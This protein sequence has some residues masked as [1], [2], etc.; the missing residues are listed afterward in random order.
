MSRPPIHRPSPSPRGNSRYFG[1]DFNA[2]VALAEAVARDGH[3]IE[4]PAK[5]RGLA[6]TL[7]ELPALV[8]HILGEHQ[9]LYAR[10]ACLGSARLAENLTRH[11]RKLAYSPGPG[12]AATGLA[13]FTV[14]PGLSGSLPQGFALQTSPL[15]EARAQTFETLAEAQL[16][17]QWNA[18]RPAGAEIPDPV[19]AS[20]GHLVLRLKKRHGLGKDEIVV[21]DGARGLG[22]F[23]VADAMEGSRPPQIGLRHIGGHAFAEAGT[24]ADWQASYRILAR[25]RHD[26][27]LFGWNAPG[28]LWPAG[29]LAAAQPYASPPTT[30]PAGTTAFGYVSPAAL[31]DALLLAEALNDPPAP[32]DA[33]V[34]LFPDRAEVYWLE[35]LAET[36]VT[37]LRGEV[38]EQP[39][40]A[41]STNAAGA[42]V[43]SVTTEK[44]VTETAL[45]GRATTLGLAMPSPARPLRSWT[46]FPLDAHVL[47]GWSEVLEPLP[48][49]P[50]PAPLQPEFAVAAD[51][52]AMRPGRP[53][54]LRRVSTGEAREAIF[55]AIKA[56][57]AGSEGWTLRLEVPGGF[58][59]GW[60]MG[61][62]EV[63]GNVVRVSHGEAKQE[64]LGS[65]DGVTP[66][67]EFALKN[68]PV[69]RLPGALGS[70][71]A[72]EVRV[73]GVLW[74]LAPD[75]H[76]AGPDARVH[77]AQTDAAG[78]V[79]IRFGGEGRGAIPPSGRRNV[80]A[81]Y[82]CGLGAAGNAGA[83]RL[84]RIRKASPLIGAVT[85]PLPIAGG[86]DPAG[87][88]DI[89]RQAVR[90]VRVFDRA[91]SIEDHADLALL[92]PGISRA[93]ARWRDGVG[94]ELVA[95]DAEGNGPAD[96]AGFTA[97]LD[98]RRDTGQALVVAAPQA[99]D[100]A[101]AL[102]IERD[103][104][105]LAEAARHEAEALL[106]GGGG[107]PGLFSFAGR[108]LS[109]PQSL[110][111]LYAQLL[112][113][114]GIAAV[115]ATRYRLA[116]PA[117][118][119]AEVADIIHAST[120][121][122]LRLKPSALE[123]QVLEPGAL[124]RL[125]QGGAP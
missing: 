20:G 29:A 67:Q 57:A 60:P 89:A 124:G 70:R 42:A 61:D 87:A 25:P 107:L 13:A 58:P 48:A 51:L 115:L 49:I 34:V 55:A 16:D 33:A 37:F 12:A 14:K 112:D 63:L 56:P 73:D 113:R 79:R 41:T 52:S 31:G 84:S 108:E 119:T 18:I 11:A 94:I 53:A 36:V 26:A 3:G 83:G 50:N 66:H 35:T 114:P 59:A 103:R 5:G 90:P 96:L 23:R 81:A 8:A 104:A 64:I 46:E 122:W 110:S 120:R 105:W 118:G 24:G 43:V 74:D 88:D 62:V 93:S 32:G 77:L 72:L 44:T 39:K 95:A 99:V 102:R 7:I 125:Q 40:V 22:V 15:G 100:I 101:L 76:G 111:G 45:S 1:P 47:T 38:T 116:L 69:T 106:L 27:R 98:A 82:R 68:A 65:S 123:I 21:L 28:A 91:V 2:L 86:A 85:N 6:R 75:F 92:F 117:A 9:G 4:I 78:E 80:T 30:Q 19:Q 17:A 54:I 121:Q 97:F 109:A 71:M 10:E